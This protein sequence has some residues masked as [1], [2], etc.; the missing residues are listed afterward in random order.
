MPLRRGRHSDSVI[1]ERI[2][3]ASDNAYPM[4]SSSCGGLA[5]VNRAA[6]PF[7]VDTV[8]PEK[9]ALTPLFRLEVAERGSG[10]ESV[11]KDMISGHTLPLECT[12]VGLGSK[13]TRV[14]GTTLIGGQHQR[15]GAGV[16]CRAR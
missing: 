4:I 10:V 5:F 6:Y 1:D 13:D 14:S 9:V 16:D 3:A 15:I 8:I 7:P 11:A 12:D 2:L